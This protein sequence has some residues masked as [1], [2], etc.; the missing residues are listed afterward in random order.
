M[1]YD[2]VLISLLFRD[3]TKTMPNQTPSIKKAVIVFLV[4]LCWIGVNAQFI[5]ERRLNAK[6]GYGLSFAENSVDDAFSDGLYLQGEY[7]LKVTSWVAF[8]PYGGL[9]LTSKKGKTLDDAPTNEVA[10]S[11]ALLLGGK[12]RV[13]A[14]IPYVAPYFEIGI[15]T[16]IGRF[17]T[18]NAVDAIRKNGVIYHVP[19]SIGVELGRRNTV[20]F[21]FTYYAQPSVGQIAG[22][23]AIGVSIPLARSNKNN[24]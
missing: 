2:F 1:N 8:K 12:I 5:K 4:S 7:V 16:S 18:L 6:I 11:K 9:L 15:G 20:D 14:P 24:E 23:T 19:F 22:A 21:G 13:R 3:K 17:E 10:S